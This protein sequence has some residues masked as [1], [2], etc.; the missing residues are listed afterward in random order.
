VQTRGYRQA[1]FLPAELF[2]W[3]SGPTA[4]NYS[5]IPS[6]VEESRG[7]TNR[8]FLGIFRLRF[9]PLKMTALPGH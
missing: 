4:L 9:A 3:L 6:E 8:R 7:E 2:L 5:V 1:Q